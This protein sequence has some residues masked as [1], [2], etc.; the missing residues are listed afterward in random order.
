MKK[1]IVNLIYDLL[2]L[3]LS[4]ILTWFAYLMLGTVICLTL[5]P[6]VFQNETIYKSLLSIFLLMLFSMI[7][8]FFETKRKITYY[9]KSYDLNIAILIS[10]LA[11]INMFSNSIFSFFVKPLF[12]LPI[13]NPKISNIISI[14]IILAAYYPYL[15][16][17]R[18]RLAIHY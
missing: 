2:C 8:V 16:L 7:L 9:F 4:L 11:L 18:K 14:L 1:Y 10:L 5:K 15:Y 3:L 17:C 6:I 13:E 12:M